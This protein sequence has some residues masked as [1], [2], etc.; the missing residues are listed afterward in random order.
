MANNR[1]TEK[2]NSPVA[3]IGVLI[4]L[5]AVNVRVGIAATVI[6]IIFAM[7]NLIKSASREN[8]A[9][10]LGNKTHSHDRL[11]PTVHMESGLEHYK[12]QLDGF[13]KS[14]II[15]RA[16]YNVLMKKYSERLRAK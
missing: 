11:D 2:K 4:F 10:S 8:T 13:L 5:F 14:G 16:E 3:A 15:D 12:I 1:Q 7:I 9:G 6:Y